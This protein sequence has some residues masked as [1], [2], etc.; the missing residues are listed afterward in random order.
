MLRHVNGEF[1]L[2]ITGMS[3]CTSPIAPFN[4][5]RRNIWCHDCFA[6]DQAGTDVCVGAGPACRVMVTNQSACRSTQKS[7]ADFNKSAAIILSAWLL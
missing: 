5:F 2:I 3:K 6:R 1:V 7:C 4:I